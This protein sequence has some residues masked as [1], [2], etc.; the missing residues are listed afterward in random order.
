MWLQVKAVVTGCVD[1]FTLP[2]A[3]TQA[4]TP[5]I[6]TMDEDLVQDAADREISGAI[7]NVRFRVALRK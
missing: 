2:I 4:A 7:V 1:V 6:A 5:H 3:L